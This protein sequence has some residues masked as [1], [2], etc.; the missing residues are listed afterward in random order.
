LGR[1]P[2]QYKESLKGLEVETNI[3]KRRKRI[4]K[5]ILVFALA[6]VLVFG[7]AATAFAIDVAGKADSIKLSGHYLIR[8]HADNNVSD[9]CDSDGDLC[10]DH[11][12]FYKQRLRLQ[13][14]INVAEGVTAV[15][16]MDIAESNLGDG[17]ASNDEVDIDHAYLKL[18]DVFGISW[19]LGRQPASWGPTHIYTTG[20]T[21]D[22][23][24]AIKKIGGAKVGAVI[25]KNNETYDGRGG[26]DSDSYY[27][28]AVIPAGEG[29]VGLLYKDTH[30]NDTD[31]D[32]NATEM[33]LYYAGKVGPVGLAVE[34]ITQ[35]SD[36][37]T[38]TTGQVDAKT[39]MIV[40]GSMDVN[41]AINVGLAYASAANSYQA[42]DDFAATLLFGTNVNPTA[43]MNFGVTASADPITGE[44]NDTVSAIVVSGKMKVSDDLTMGAN[45]A[46]ATLSDNA[47][48]DLTEIDLWGSLKIAGNTSLWLGYAMGMPDAPGATDTDNIT[49]AAWQVKTVF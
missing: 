47:E 17:G 26:G 38:G 35:D 10:N 19:T 13:L 42:D 22:R 14:G 39:A 48:V 45:I 31:A 16:R 24:K 1:Q 46:Q 27:V 49:S 33:A 20:A 9:W 30:A 7:F 25:Q 11:N 23:I 3:I 36:A 37:Y 28:V 44:N 32:D 18:A 5:R 15:T 43:V 4:V 12:N 6:V 41:D 34:Y 40:A 2:V 8:G 21:K 29:K